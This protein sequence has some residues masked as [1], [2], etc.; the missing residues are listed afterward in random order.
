VTFFFDEN[1]PKKLVEALKHLGRDVCHATGEF[2]RGTPDTEW[3]PEVARREW[4][5]VT[6]DGSILRKKNEYALARSCG[7]RLFVVTGASGFWKLV[8]TVVRNFEEM[9]RISEAERPRCYQIRLKGP[10]KP[11]R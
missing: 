1:M 4:V 10:P 7:L 2:D 11:L 8:V 6:Q 5:A 3:I 9:E